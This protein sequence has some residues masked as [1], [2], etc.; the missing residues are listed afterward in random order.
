[1]S[2][3]AILTV[4]AKASCCVLRS[5]ALIRYTFRR[6]AD[7]RTQLFLRE[8]N[9][10]TEAYEI[11][12]FLLAPGLVVWQQ[13]AYIEV[14]EPR[15]VGTLGVLTIGGFKD[16]RGEFF[17]TEPFNAK[18]ILVRNVWP[19]ITLNSCRFEQSFSPDGGKTW[20]VNWVATDTRIKDE[21][22]GIR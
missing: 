3:E 5:L 2:P 8:G 9:E 19:D 11:G 12:R 22:D 10:H 15:V 4:D 21:S 7:L 14:Q 6:W 13:A 17:D 20:E 18:N 1:M 16:G